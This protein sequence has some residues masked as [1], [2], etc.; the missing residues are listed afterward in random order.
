MAY[1]YCKLSDNIGVI[2]IMIKKIFTLFVLMLFVVSCLKDGNTAKKEAL[3]KKYSDM[4]KAVNKKDINWFKNNSI[5]E[6]NTDTLKN[7]LFENNVSL[8]N[9]II[10]KGTSEYTVT[11]SY[12]AADSFSEYQNTGY[13]I[14]RLNEYS[15]NYFYIHLIYRTNKWLIDEIEMLP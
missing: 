7:I 13:Y 4:E 1:S 8:R 15:A 14:I 9:F 11:F 5:K 10:K 12:K 3:I 2:L 6:L